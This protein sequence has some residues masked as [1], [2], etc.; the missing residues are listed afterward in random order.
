MGP[1]SNAGWFRRGID[2]LKL[3]A[4]QGYRLEDV[5]NLAHHRDL[6][7][8]TPGRHLPGRQPAA[9]RSTTQRPTTRRPPWNDVIVA[10]RNVCSPHQG[11]RRRGRCG[12]KPLRSR[13]PEPAGLYSILI[14]SRPGS[15]DVGRS[16][17][18][19]KAAR[20]RGLDPAVGEDRPAYRPHRTIQASVRTSVLLMLA[21][22][23]VMLVVFLFLRNFWASSSRASP[24]AVVA[25]RAPP[26]RSP[27]AVG[28][29]LDNLI[30]ALC[31][32]VSS[33]WMTP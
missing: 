2:P 10:Y 21:I 11:H 9:S 28:Y 6:V 5:A 27:Y 4:V 30:M 15:D 3:A 1:G 29:S 17:S 32:A 13:L 12:R 25:R 26:R 16:K 23:L 24:S 22:I 8:Y 20:R 19:V 31:I 7:N 33:W 14:Y 18:G